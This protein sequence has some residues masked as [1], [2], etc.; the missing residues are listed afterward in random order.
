MAPLSGAEPGGDIVKKIGW[1]IALAVAGCGF[2]QNDPFHERPVASRAEAPPPIAGGT[3][4]LTRDGRFALAADPDLDRLM[5]VDLSTFE[6][7][8]VPLREGDE[9]GRIAED[10]SGRAYVALRSGAAVAEVDVAEAR[11]LRLLAV[12]EAPRGLAWEAS[13]DRL[14]V[15]CADGS[16]VALGPDRRE[17][18]RVQLEPGLRDVVTTDDGLLLTRFRSADVIHLSQAGV[19]R[20]RPLPQAEQRGIDD[21]GDATQLR[22]SYAP[23]V[24]VRLR[25]VEGG[26]VVLHQ[27]ARVGEEAVYREAVRPSA[28]SY[29]Y[30][31][32]PVTYRDITWRDPCDNAVVHSAATFVR[33]DGAAQ[34]VAPA[35]VRGVVPVDVAVS[36]EGQ[37]AIAFAG[38]PGGDFAFGPQVLRSEARSAMAEGGCLADQG[39]GSFPGQAVAVAYAGETLVAQLRAPA[40]LMIGDAV[41]ELGGEVVRDTGHEIFHLDT[42]GAVACASCHPGGGDDG[43]VWEFAAVSPVRTQP[44]EGVV[45]LAPYH[46]SGNVASFEELVSGLAEQMAGPQLDAPQRDALRGWLLRLPSAPSGPAGEPA[47]VEHGRE[48]FVSAGCESCHAGELGTDGRSHRIGGTMLQTPPLLGVALRGPYLHDGRAPHLEQALHGEG[49][50]LTAADRADLVTYLRSL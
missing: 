23:G 7:T 19:V 29:T 36:A 15:A 38:E 8:E 25:S 21:D 32:R 9:P 16:L 4:T 39:Q 1:L 31:N 17:A 46:R 14:H 3:L 20:T 2:N 42:G 6:V 28:S 30:S 50:A 5:R 44:L 41:V 11:L 49:D 47:S 10:G 48:I 43:H 37:V 34:H 12:C 24:A 35:L 27:R 33:P 40:R 45:E 13:S 22:Q 26:H 18:G